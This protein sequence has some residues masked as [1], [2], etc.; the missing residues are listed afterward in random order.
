MRRRAGSGPQL[1]ALGEHPVLGRRLAEHV[2]AL[3]LDQLQP[4]GGVEAGV[5][6]HRRGPAEPGGDEDVARRL[7]PAASP[8]CTRPARPR[9]APSQC[10]AWARWPG[11]VAL[12]VQGAARLAGRPRGEDDQRAVLGVEVGRLGRRLLRALL[13]DHRGDVGHRHRRHAVREA[14]RAAPPRRRRAPAF[15]ARTRSSRSC[16]AKLRVAGQRDRAHPPAGEHREHPLDPVADQGH[17][18]VAAAHPARRER[19]REPGAARDQLAEGP[20]PPLA[21]ARDRHQGRLRGREA[22]QHVLDEVHGRRSLPIDG[23]RSDEWR[24]SAASNRGIGREIARQLAE[25]GH[26][27]IVTARDPAARRGAPPRSSRTA[28]GCRSRRSSSTSP[29]RAASSACASGSRPSPA[30][31]TCWSTTPAS[32][33][34]VATNVSQAPL[35]DAHR[36]LETNLFGAWR[37]DPGDAAARCAAAST[38]GSSTCSSGAGQLSDMNGGYPGYRISKTALNALTAAS[39]S[40]EEGGNGILVNSMCPG[41]VAHRHGRLGG[42][43][44]RRARA[45]TRR[46][47]SRPCPTTA[48]PAA[49][50]AI[51]S[52]S[53]GSVPGSARRSSVPS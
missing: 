10:S 28:A 34:E 14:R 4:L 3:A 18:H 16:A 13:V 5:V 43:A 2:D 21:V 47:G 6:D 27:V 46:C 32:M 17:H 15:A 8:S 40:K 23:R 30:A 50:S 26:H 29:T 9:G 7:R 45:P 51:A 12:G 19:A 1:G 31:S 53:P 36:T 49:S 20:D 11:Q 35:D 33:G 24:W 48:P 38:A 25:L 52:R 42:S 22:L 41:W 37:L 44:L 39:S